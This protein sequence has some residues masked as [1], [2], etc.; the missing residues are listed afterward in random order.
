MKKV[1]VM[2]WILALILFCSTIKI[3]AD[4][5]TTTYWNNYYSD[6][7]K[8]TQ[9][10]YTGNYG[11][12]TLTTNGSGLTTINIYTSNT[13]VYSNTRQYI[14]IPFILTGQT[15]H[16]DSN[17]IDK[18]I[19]C[20]YG[21]VA[22]NE[23]DGFDYEPYNC[24]TYATGTYSSA[25]DVNLTFN[26]SLR[27]TAGNEVPCIIESNF[28]KCYLQPNYNYE[29]IRIEYNLPVSNNWY[30]LKIGIK[31]AI[32]I[33]ADSQMQI[34]QGI[35]QQTQQQQN[36]YNNMMNET[37]TYDNN[38]NT[39]QNGANETMEWGQ[40]EEALMNQLDMNTTMLSDIN[41]NPTAAAF[42]WD[43]VG[44]LR[45]MNPAIVMLFTSLLGLGVARMLL[46]R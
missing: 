7:N 25:T 42:I 21:P 12:S 26:I 19:I 17:N 6:S 33:Y 34:Q 45:N 29:V 18:E 31:R 20:N 16:Y 39:N 27:T 15:S 10:S 23:Q 4:T 28:A 37:R 41:I 43:I 22:G 13:F 36:N 32:G 2:P 40:Q 38:I 44:G 35:E 46:N 24:T 5:I 9:L 3:K 11:M 8:T 30:D 1:L 14:L